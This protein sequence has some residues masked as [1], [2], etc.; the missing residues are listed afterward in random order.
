MSVQN[1]R[2]LEGDQSKSHRELKNRNNQL[3]DRLDGQRQPVVPCVSPK[4]ACVRHRTSRAR[5]TP[6]HAVLARARVRGDAT[7]EL[8][9]GD[10]AI[11]DERQ[12]VPGRENEGNKRQPELSVEEDKYEGPHPTQ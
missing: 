9:D 12:G 8:R 7:H 1:S 3:Y 2:G 6:S 5:A 10:E 11:E 4:L